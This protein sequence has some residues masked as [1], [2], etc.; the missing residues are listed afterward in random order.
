MRVWDPPQQQQARQESP[1]EVLRC[2]FDRPD[3]QSSRAKAQ[4]LFLCAIW[5]RS[6]GWAWGAEP[7]AWGQK[8]GSRGRRSKRSGVLIALSTGLALVLAAR[9][10]LDLP[11]AVS[12]QDEDMGHFE[13]PEP[14]EEST[15]SLV[16]SSTSAYSSFPVDVVV[17]VRVQ[18]GSA[19]LP[20]SFDLSTQVLCGPVAF[21]GLA[22]LRVHRTEAARR[23]APGGAPVQFPVCAFLPRRVFKV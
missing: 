12:S 23:P 15:A 7:E 20:Q 10:K 16:S 17:Y 6:G 14:M 11:T 13:I 22:G 19:A 8:C 5:R 2:L 21:P 18:V 1:P 4:L 9:L 3:G